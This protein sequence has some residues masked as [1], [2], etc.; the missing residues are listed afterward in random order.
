MNREKGIQLF[1]A[2]ISC[3]MISNSLELEA[4]AAGEGRERC[5]F[6]TVR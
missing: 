3:V 4:C 1:W 6:I 2:F 5:A